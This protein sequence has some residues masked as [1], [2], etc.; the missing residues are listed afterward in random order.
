MALTKRAVEGSSSSRKNSDSDIADSSSKDTPKTPLWE[1]A[2]TPNSDGLW[3]KD[4]L[5]TVLHWIRQVIG[6]VFGLMFGL[7]PLTGFV[8]NMSFLGGVTI[9][10]YLYYA[11]FLAVDEEEFGRFE[12]LSEGF[13]NSYA[14][15]L[16][17]L[18]F[19]E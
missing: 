19:S 1:L 4:D 6:I 12:L 16:V 9:V 18:L 5:F 14:L 13:M 10:T 8:G 15:F 11:K 3:E 7:L 2:K 17:G